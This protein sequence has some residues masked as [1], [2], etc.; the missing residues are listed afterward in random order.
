MHAVRQLYPE[1]RLFG[2]KRDAMFDKVCGT[3]RVRRLFLEGRPIDEVIAFWG[4][5][6]E[7]FRARRVPYLLYD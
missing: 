1:T 7:E 4:E 2:N 3:D 5:G 6:V